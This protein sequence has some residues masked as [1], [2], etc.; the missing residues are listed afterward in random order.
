MK[1]VK[2]LLLLL[3]ISCAAIESVEVIN[4][5]YEKA[6]LGGGCYWGMEPTFED[7]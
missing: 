2:V 3:F 5:K 1:S 4:D 6:N 7:L